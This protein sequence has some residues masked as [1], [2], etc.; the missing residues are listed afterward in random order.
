MTDHTESL[1]HVVLGLASSQAVGNAILAAAG[2]TTPAVTG[3]TVKIDGSLSGES[4]DDLPSY[5]TNINVFAAVPLGSLVEHNIKENSSS[6]LCVDLALVFSDS[7]PKTTFIPKGQTLLLPQ[8]FNSTKQ[9]SDTFL[10]H[11]E[12]TK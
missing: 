11:W 8:Q 3:A 2:L 5:P 6:N 1:R 4:G 7:V 10:G 9:W 12:N